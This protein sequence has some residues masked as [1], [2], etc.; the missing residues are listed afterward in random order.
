M[1]ITELFP[2]T[3]YGWAKTRH[4]GVFPVP[5]GTVSCEDLKPSSEKSQPSGEALLTL[6]LLIVCGT[7]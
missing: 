2:A 6:I 7:Q 4:T 3:E 1:Q 5:V